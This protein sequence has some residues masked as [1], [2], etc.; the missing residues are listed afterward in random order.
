ML[1]LEFQS[2]GVFV[3]FVGFKVYAAM[4]LQR[5]Q[6]EAL[7]PLFVGLRA[8]DRHPSWYRRSFGQAGASEHH[9][10]SE[11]IGNPC[12]FHVWVSNICGNLDF[13]DKQQQTH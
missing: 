2:A 3:F 9:L 6:T 13:L 12:V 11:A 8:E 4:R 10:F 1:S 5:I 7:Q